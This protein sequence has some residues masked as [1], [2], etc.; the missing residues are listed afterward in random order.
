MIVLALPVSASMSLAY[1]RCIILLTLMSIVML[2]SLQMS[3]I[4]IAL[5]TTSA[6]KATNVLVCH[7]TVLLLS[8]DDILPRDSSH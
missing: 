5:E 3:N 7:M 4:I 8:S 1:N 2:Y 6:V